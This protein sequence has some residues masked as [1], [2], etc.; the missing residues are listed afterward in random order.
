MDTQ[1]VIRAQRGDETAFADLTVAV[2]GQ[3]HRVAYG[4]LR[5]RGNAEDATQRGFAQ[6]WR[7]LPTLKDPARFEAW[8]YRLVVH[9]CY[10]EAR[11]AKRWLPGLL[12]G[13]ER[14]A[15]D[16]ISAVDD[17]DQLERGFR[18]LSVDQRAVIVLHDYLGMPLSEVART[19]GIPAGT[20][21]SRHDRAMAKLRQ[22][23]GAVVAA[24]PLAPTEVP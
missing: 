11:R 20:A 13:R 3:L 5:D 14:L 8:A 15:P 22:A 16:E 21:R 12:L 17:R 6:I 24:A 18:R 9:A 4:I 10:A 1:L 23:L 19:L 7:K 2:G